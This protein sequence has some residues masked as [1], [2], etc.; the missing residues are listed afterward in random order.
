MIK[1]MTVR[2][3][4]RAKAPPGSINLLQESLYAGVIGLQESSA[5]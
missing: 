3:R 2:Y 4:G 1:P 5:E